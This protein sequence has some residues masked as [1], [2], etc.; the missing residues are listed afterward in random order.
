MFRPQHAGVEILKVKKWL[1]RITTDKKEDSKEKEKIT[2]VET[3]NL[4]TDHGTLAYKSHE[5]T[6]DYEGNNALRVYFTYTNKSEDTKNAMFA[7]HVQIF[8]NSVECETAIAD[9]QNPVESDNNTL[10]DVMKDGT[11]DVSYVYKV[12]DTTSPIM[13]KAKDIVNMFD[14]IYQEQDVTLQ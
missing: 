14:D 8:Q 7:F 5:L 9:Y 2:K 4:E 10:K 6:Q 1:P 3:I 12:Q 11:L 13:I